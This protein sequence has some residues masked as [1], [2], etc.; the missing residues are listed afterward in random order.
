MRPS[1]MLSDTL[2]AA[3]PISSASDFRFPRTFASIAPTRSMT[4]SETS[5]QSNMIFP[6]V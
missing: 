6:F 5:R 2:S 3:R 4:S 1:L